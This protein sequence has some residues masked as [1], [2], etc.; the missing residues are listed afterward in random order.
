MSWQTET[1]A[2]LPPLP[3]EGRWWGNPLRENRWQFELAQLLVEP[4]FRG[5]GLP[6]GD[7]RAVVLMPG[8]G[9]GDLT[10]LVLAG[11]LQRLVPTPD[12]PGFLDSH[13][14]GVSP[15][16]HQFHEEKRHAIG[17]HNRRFVRPRPNRHE[18]AVMQTMSHVDA[19]FLH[20]EDAVSHMHIGPVGIFEG[21]APGPGEVPAA[22]AARLPAVPRYRQKVA[23]V[24]LDLG[25]P[26]WVDDPHF[27]LDYHIRR[28][29]LP[30]PGGDEELRNL[31]GRVMSQQLDRSKPLWELWVVEGL[32]EGR[33]ALISKVHHCMVDGVAASDLLSV[34]LDSERD[35]GPPAPDAWTPGPEPS[36]AELVARAL[37][38][39]AASPYEGLRAALAAV[40][41]PHRLV[42]EGLEVGRGLAHLQRVTAPGSATSLNGPLGPHRRWAWARSKLADVKRIREAHGG[43]VNDVVLA[44]ITGGFRA[45]LLARGEDVQARVVR[46]TVPVS[47]RAGHERGAYDNKVSAMFADLPVNIADP[48]ARLE[49]IRQQMH[50]LKRSGQAVAAERLTALSGFAPAEL[51]ALAG[52]A[53]SQVPQRAVNTVTTNV[54]G[55]QHPLFLC[56]RRMLEAF[57]WCPLVGHLR[58]GVAIFSY[59]GNLTFGVTGDHDTTPD[60]S[61][62]CEG[63]ERGIAQ[64]LPGSPPNGAPRRRHSAATTRP[65]A[66]QP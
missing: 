35:P 22:I 14:V 54:P 11:W 17:Q 36:P 56:G 49:S 41:D 16:P 45:L 38:E 28:T 29:A 21:P 7:G 31:V 57:P 66:A 46:T 19:S 64:L 32:D 61:V 34:L 20:V 30:S 10:L 43:T 1:S 53:A 65:E 13:P 2:R 26:V 62:L 5:N 3:P 42:R 15:Q 23:F 8:L 40:R 25:R 47:V 24:P 55:P 18:G 44:A 33:W 39:R 27:N 52:R 6:R 37:A 58:I 51:L 60:I 63:I 9:G 4:V 50:T 12:L 48:V 59:D